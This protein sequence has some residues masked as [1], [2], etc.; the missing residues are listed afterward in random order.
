MRNT[1]RRRL[2][3]A[4]KSP[5]QKPAGDSIGAQ[6]T[7]VVTDAA[8]RAERRMLQLHPKSGLS[9]GRSYI[10][11]VGCPAAGATSQKWSVPRP[12]V[13]PKSGM[14]RGRSY[15]PKVV[16]PAAEGTSQKWDVPRPKVHH[17]SM[18]FRGRRYIILV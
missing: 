12:E 18:M 10:P 3:Q 16:C 2:A 15:I 9:R 17:T 7:A 4:A 6:F 5:A 1:L 11:K 14:F 13:H 8:C